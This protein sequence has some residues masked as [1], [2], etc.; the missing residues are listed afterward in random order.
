MKQKITGLKM[1]S[2]RFHQ[3]VG[4][5]ACHRIADLIN[6]PAMIVKSSHVNHALLE[7]D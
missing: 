7:N 5:A 3:R 4:K 1:L 2:A 6:N